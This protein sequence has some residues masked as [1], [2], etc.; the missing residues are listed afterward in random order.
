MALSGYVHPAWAD[1]AGALSRQLPR[2]GAGGAAV[3][4][5]HRGHC[6]VDVWG[7]TRD[8]EGRPWLEDTVA[9]SFSTTKGVL[10][11]LLHVLLEQRGIDFDRPVVEFWPELAAG[12]KAEMTLRHVLCH[13]AGLYRMSDLTRTP[14]HMLDWEG[15][16]ARLV[17]ATPAHSPGQAHGYHALTYGWLAGGLAEIIGEQP[18]EALLASELAGPLGLDGLYIGLPEAALSRRARLIHNDGIV[19]PVRV[20][21]RG[22]RATL[23]RW[24]HAG[25]CRAGID[26]AEFRSAL[27]PFTEPFDWNADETVMAKIPAA[28]GQFTARSLARVY[29]MLAERG[30]LDGVRLLTRER[31]DTIAQVQSWQRDR[32]LFLPMHWRL[33]YHRV[34]APGRRVPMGFGH[35]GFGGSGAWA[36]PERRIALG[37]TLNS[38]VGTP[39]GDLR[40]SRLNRVVLATV[41][42]LR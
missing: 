39:M 4:V 21:E 30:V 7:G 11:T 26:F 20:S 16:K 6:V 24:V 27:T 3:C 12:I 9:P 29:A 8:R 17:A 19:L 2:R 13:Q 25:L 40:I 32:V 22:L 28:N 14:R 36:D 23:R 18:L 35:F 37:L 33:G 5:Y 41:D 1:V 31:V 42:R 34:F 10:S 38:G 15:M